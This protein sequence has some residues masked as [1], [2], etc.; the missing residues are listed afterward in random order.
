M[1]LGGRGWRGGTGWGPP[2]ESWIG[3]SKEV[4]LWEDPAFEWQGSCAEGLLVPGKVCGEGLCG[5]GLLGVTGVH[6]FFASQL[7]AWMVPGYIKSCRVWFADFLFLWD[8]PFGATVAGYLCRRLPGVRG[9]L[10]FWV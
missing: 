3:K 6:S 1:G 5:K 8:V 4:G 9:D 7:V 2:E 10:G